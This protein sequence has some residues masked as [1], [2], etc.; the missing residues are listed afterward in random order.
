MSVAVLLPIAVFSALECAFNL[1]GVLRVIKRAE[2]VIG[3]DV[4]STSETGEA[5][6]HV[7]ESVHPNAWEGI[8]VR[9][10]CV[11][12]STKLIDPE[13]WIY[14]IPLYRTVRWT[15]TGRQKRSLT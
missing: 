15:A 3:A 8:V 10:R 14:L 5:D 4:L 12:D 2:G 13:G 7:I 11:F 6:Q 9:C 1:H